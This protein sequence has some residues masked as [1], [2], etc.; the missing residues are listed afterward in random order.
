[1]DKQ[2]ME[3]LIKDYQEIRA[4]E[5]SLG[6]TIGFKARL[7]RA[8]RLDRY[9]IKVRI[10]T[11]TKNWKNNI[12]IMEMPICFDIDLPADYPNK[13][14]RCLF[15]KQSTCKLFHP[16]LTSKIFS[17]ALTWQNPFYNPADGLAQYVLNLIKSL[18]YN[19]DF[20]DIQFK[21][22]NKAAM[23]WYI[24]KSKQ[25]PSF[26]PTDKS[27]LSPS[28]KTFRMKEQTKSINQKKFIIKE[29]T[30]PYQPEERIMSSF[31][32][33]AKFHRPIEQTGNH[34]V[35][36]ITEDA[37]QQIVNF[38]DYGQTTRLNCVEQGGILIGKV[39]KD[40]QKNCIYGIVNEIVPASTAKGTAAYLEIDHSTWAEMFNKVDSLLSSGNEKDT[41]I[42]GWF[43]THPNELGIF[44][45][46][47]DRE[48]QARVFNQNWHF[49]VVLNP[50]KQ[51]Y[52]VFNGPNA[53]PCKGY[54][55][56]NA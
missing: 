55:I 35:L 36:F 3:R 1:M 17:N 43:H 27:L 8:N 39:Y 5:E 25:D 56:K 47:T 54:I 46:G 52:G 4:L 41:H 53:E 23:D 48:T 49:A 37:M 45:S 33:S 12:Q 19:P 42:I 44:M 13:P 20:I 22:G 26:F 15:Y 9:E 6:K 32:E 16:Y 24:Q 11:A 29:V 31:S 18:Q 7:I 30:P 34:N 50:Q 40:P 10:K 2:H 28:P 51:I 38:I 14:P 21:D